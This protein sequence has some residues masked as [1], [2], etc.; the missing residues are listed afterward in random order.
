MKKK[1]DDSTLGLR[2]ISKTQSATRWNMYAARSTRV[3][4]QRACLTLRVTTSR[5]RQALF[6]WVRLFR[7]AA[8]L[9]LLM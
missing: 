4:R 2:A 6:V 5:K 3:A 1:K 9:V 7:I 8:A